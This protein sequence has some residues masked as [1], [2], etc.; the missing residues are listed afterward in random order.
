VGP[1]FPN[2]SVDCDLFL[3]ID[4]T[5]QSSTTWT[6]RPRRAD[7]D[8]DDGA[9][10]SVDSCLEVE[11]QL[12][13]GVLLE[14]PFGVDPNAG[15]VVLRYEWP[16]SGAS[17]LSSGF[18]CSGRVEGDEEEDSGSV[19]LLADFG[20]QGGFTL[21]SITGVDAQGVPVPGARV[22]S[23]TGHDYAMPPP[24]LEPL[25]VPEPGAGALGG[26]VLLALAELRRSATRRGRGRT[27]PPD[28]APPVPGSGSEE[29]GLR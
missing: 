12:E 10:A 27:S 20:T 3:R 17:Q 11:H 16:V 25:A 2:A 14:T 19:E 7:E 6:W 13:D 24:A 4:G 9:T 22:V 21:R 18:V 8:C 1:A 5:L 28:P 29:P 23:D 26:A 15:P